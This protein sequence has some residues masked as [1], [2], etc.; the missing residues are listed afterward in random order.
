MLGIRVCL[1]LFLS[2]CVCVDS[3]WKLWFVFVSILLRF[4]IT[5]RKR[6]LLCACAHLRTHCAVVVETPPLTLKHTYTHKAVECDCEWAYSREAFIHRCFV[7]RLI[8]QPRPFGVT[9]CELYTSD[10]SYIL[11]GSFHLQTGINHMS[12]RGFVASIYNILSDTN[13]YT[14][15]MD[16][17][18]YDLFSLTR[19][20]NTLHNRYDGR[21]TTIDV[22]VLMWFMVFC[23]VHMPEINTGLSSV[24]F[25]SQ[26]LC[27]T[28]LEVILIHLFAYETIFSFCLRNDSKWF[29]S[30]RLADIH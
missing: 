24:H 22:I 17:R 2:V 9:R 7:T 20:F 6:F 15:C 4:R 13:S 14:P 10:A 18:K 21:V 19:L 11:S 5:N 23:V 1:C 16:W 28:S 8:F 30:V 29:P 26:I 27:L 3:P 25:R 12:R